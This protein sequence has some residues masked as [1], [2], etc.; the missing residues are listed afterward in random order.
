MN[1][2]NNTTK[3]LKIMIL[4]LGLLCAIFVFGFFTRNDPSAV[5]LAEE[6]SVKVDELNETVDTLSSANDS[7]TQKLLDFQT[8]NEE[9][10]EMNHVL[11][12]KIQELNK[13][14]EIASL[15]DVERYVNYVYDIAAEY[16]PDIHP[17][18]VCAI[19]YHES[20]FD[21]T[22]TNSNTGVK[23]LCQINPKWHTKRANNL[24]VEDL[25]DPYGN[26]LV[27]FDILNE[28]S[29]SGSFS[30]A[31]NFYAGGYPYAKRYLNETSPFEKELKQ[32]IDEQNFAQYVLPYSII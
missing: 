26:I 4:L 21:P 22:Q 16:Y 25:Y 7:L 15:S 10:A 5:R 11:T 6:L 27:C 20:R 32:I 2:T 31:L 29:Y 17:E 9:L 1:T 18:Y 12:L 3:L 19:I 28:L 23:G 13:Q 30:H 8:D 14:I 24:G